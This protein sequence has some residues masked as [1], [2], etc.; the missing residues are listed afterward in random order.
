[1]KKI[2][3]ATAIF[4]ASIFILTSNK[5]FAQDFLPEAAKISKTTDTFKKFF[6][7][8]KDF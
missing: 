3:I 6:E 4:I 1:M 8:G 5:A 2:F 7:K